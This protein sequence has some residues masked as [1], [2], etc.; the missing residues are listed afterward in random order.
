MANAALHTPCELGGHTEEKEG[1]QLAEILVG[2]ALLFKQL[3][4]GL[5]SSSSRFCSCSARRQAER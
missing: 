3:P 2:A 5:F 4:V 1:L